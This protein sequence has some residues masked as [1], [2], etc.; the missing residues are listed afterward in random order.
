MR[1]RHKALSALPGAPGSDTELGNYYLLPS[2]KGR[3]LAEIGDRHAARACYT[4]GGPSAGLPGY[5]S[6]ATSTDGYRERSPES[7]VTSSAP[8]AWAKAAR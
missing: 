2:G 1:R 6:T 7:R 4:A 3:L 8:T 5:R